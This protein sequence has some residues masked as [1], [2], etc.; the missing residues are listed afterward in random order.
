MISFDWSFA[1]RYQE[2][3]SAGVTP[4]QRRPQPSWAAALAP[5]RRGEQGHS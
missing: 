5:T 3:H 2:Q 1:S 4:V